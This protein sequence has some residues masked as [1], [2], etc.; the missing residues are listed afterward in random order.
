MAQSRLDTNVIHFNLKCSNQRELYMQVLCSR[1]P[2]A[3]W[4]CVM[5]PSAGH[6][7]ISTGI[8][9]GCFHFQCMSCGP[10]DRG[11][12]FG[13]NICCGE[14]MG[15]YMGSPEAAGCVE[16]N[17]LP[18]PCEAG[19]RV[20]G[21]EGSCAASGVCCD[22][23]SCALDPDCLEDSKRQ[24]PSEQNAA[25]MGG[26]AGDLLQILHATSRGRPQ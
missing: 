17:Y 22:S 12:C 8:N 18:S 6:S 4:S 15:C 11:R 1:V 23:E 2:N 9:N 5:A 20:C 14:G 10:G 25:L 19:G 21:S 16:E 26:L 24:S 7:T 3:L 13:P